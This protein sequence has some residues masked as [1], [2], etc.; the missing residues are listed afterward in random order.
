MSLLK[1]LLISLLITCSII[2]YACK[3]SQKE[4]GV[5]ETETVIEEVTE[6]IP[7]QDETVSKSESN[8]KETGE[9]DNKF[10]PVVMSVLATPIPVK[11]SDGRFHF[12]YELLVTN[13]Y[14]LDFEVVSVEALDG[15][16]NE[17]VLTSFSG[18]EV[19]NKMQLVGT[20]AAIDSLQPGQAGII[21]MTFAVDNINDIPTNLIHRIAVTVPGGIPT[22]LFEFLELTSGQKQIIE[23][24]G[25]T[26]VGS[27]DAV[28]LG[29]PLEGSGWV[30]VNGCCD[31]TTHIRSIQPINGKLYLAQRFAIDWM[32]INEDNRIFVGDPKDVNSYFGYGKNVLAVADATVNAVVDKFKNQIPGVLP[33]EITLEEI[34]G[35]HVVLDLGNGQYVFYAH[36]QPNSIIVKEGDTVKRGQVM[37]KLGNTGNTS[38][39]HLHLHVMASP[40][41]LG[42]N[43][44]PYVFDQF[45]LLGRTTDESFLD[46]GLEDPTPIE[47]MDKAE[48][49]EGNPIQIEPDEKPGLHADE[50]P[51]DLR[52]VEF[53]SA[54]N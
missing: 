33:T 49:I 5:K 31:S 17:K 43:G 53:P 11:G 51:L 47:G 2:S 25:L 10:T 41:T 27:P 1:L 12:V 42:S 22:R 6:V 46:E 8:S 14:K 38:A 18:Q 54:S 32:K 29:P 19:L 26:K 30:V 20:R 35:N 24:G 4:T 50:L 44:L 45:D 13:A 3:D 52:I 36:V 9:T 34:D 23:T 40:Y 15:N 48:I 7:A 28:V 16:Q 37:G 21:F 39:P